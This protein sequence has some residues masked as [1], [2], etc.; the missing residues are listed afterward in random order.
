MKNKYTILVDM[1]DTIENLVDAWINYLNNQYNYSINP[2]EVVEWNISC[3]YPTVSEDR[4]YE[5]LTN[6]EF[7]KTVTP[8]Q[9]AIEYLNKLKKDGYEIKIVTASHFGTIQYKMEEVLFRY[10]PFI[11]WK[12]VVIISDKTLLKGTCLVD[13]GL[14]N[15]I[16]GD[17]DRI[18]Y[19]TPHNRNI[20]DKLFHLTRL[21]NWKEIYE[22]ITNKYI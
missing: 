21:S 8:K 6:R 16:G 14:H 3:Y 22:Y 20:D 18:L 9:D 19:D 13:D 15:L 17:Y 2:E 1:D 7:W 12:D 5:P 4:L 10:F 11:P